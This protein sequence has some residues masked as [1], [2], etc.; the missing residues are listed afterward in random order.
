MER[1]VS[2]ADR[3]LEHLV[4]WKQMLV[5]DAEP[6]T[7]TFGTATL[8]NWQSNMNEANDVKEECR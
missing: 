1:F 4:Q 5:A 7:P 3:E 6:T 2:V 8:S